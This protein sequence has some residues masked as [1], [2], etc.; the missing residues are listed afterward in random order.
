M[1]PMAHGL[2]LP[3]GRVEGDHVEEGRRRPWSSSSPLAPC[4]DLS[5]V[6]HFHFQ[7]GEGSEEWEGWKV[8]FKQ[9]QG[10]N[11]LICRLHQGLL[12]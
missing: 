2:P 12:P 9:S 10:S 8:I 7:M 1:W 4:P 5:M 6:I 3:E 11:Q